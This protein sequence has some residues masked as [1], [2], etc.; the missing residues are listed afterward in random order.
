MII[1]NINIIINKVIIY[2][3]PNTIFVGLSLS[4]V[5]WRFHFY[6]VWTAHIFIFGYVIHK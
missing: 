2:L 3:T 4:A 6:R 1:I 5:F